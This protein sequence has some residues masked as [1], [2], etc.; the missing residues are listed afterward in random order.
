MFQE[1]VDS[2]EI[3][4]LPH[5][6]PTDE[7]L[8]AILKR[9]DERGL[10]TTLLPIV[11]IERPGEKDWRGLLRPEDPNR[12][13]ESYDRFT[14][15]FLTVADQGG[16]DAYSVGS[17]LNSMEPKINRWKP[18]IERVRTEFDGPITYTANWDRYDRVKLWPLV[19]F[20][21]VSA[22]FELARDD[23]EAPLRTLTRAWSRERDRLLKF[24]R[25]QGKSFVLMELGY[26]SLPWAAAH[27]WDYVAKG[28]ARADHEAQARCYRAFFRAWAGEVARPG[29]RVLGFHCYAWDPYG[30]GEPDDTG[31]GFRGKPAMEIIRGAFEEIR[32]PAP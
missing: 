17:E 11:L 26:P 19:D 25:R 27:P 8:V 21:S 31:Y 32:R 12:W 22:Y 18:L 15:R 6:C 23:P 13:W 7:Q 30:N 14:D 4:F 2:S 3:R 5:R 9:A 24:N 16:V 20:V 10:F 1:R 28:D 29:S